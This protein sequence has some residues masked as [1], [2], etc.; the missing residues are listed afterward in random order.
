MLFS[1][2]EKAKAIQSVKLIWSA[3][4]LLSSSTLSPGGERFLSSMGARW[5]PYEQSKR[6]SRRKC[7]CQMNAEMRT[8]FRYELPLFVYC[9]FQELEW[10]RKGGFIKSYSWTILKLIFQDS[11][12]KSYSACETCSALPNY[13]SC[14]RVCWYSKHWQLSIAS[15][16]SETSCDRHRW[17]AASG[18]SGQNTAKR[19]ENLSPRKHSSQRQSQ[20][21]QPHQEI[22]HCFSLEL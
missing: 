17:S 22:A 20:Q 6:N 2:L 9:F 12:E 5:S 3:V 16:C 10:M 18:V 15:F 19:L 8:N 4:N 14:Y 11:C 13:T 1:S 21:Y 7:E